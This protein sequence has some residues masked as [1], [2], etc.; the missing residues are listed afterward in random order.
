MCDR[1]QTSVFSSLSLLS[2]VAAAVIHQRLSRGLKPR[3]AKK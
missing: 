1:S 2:R 3:N